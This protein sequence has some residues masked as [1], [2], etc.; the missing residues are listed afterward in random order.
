MLTLVQQH[1]LDRFAKSLLTL[2]DDSLID[3]Y[4]QAWE[5]IIPPDYPPRC[6]S[7]SGR[8][9]KLTVPAEPRLLIGSPEVRAR[10]CSAGRSA[11]LPAAL[12]VRSEQSRFA[13]N[14]R[15]RPNGGCP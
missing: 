10:R 7:A 15:M 8:A 2:A 11:L 14:A 1:A 4:H 5:V 6:A 12:G 3:A 9:A 13:T